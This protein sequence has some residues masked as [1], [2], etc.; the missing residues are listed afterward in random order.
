MPDSA[1]RHPQAGPLRAAIVY[2]F[3]GTLARGNLQERSFIPE[4][5]GVSHDEFWLD[6]KKTARAADADEILVYM[7]KMV[8]AARA[9]GKPFTRADLMKHGRDPDL[10]DGLDHWFDRMDA[11]A[12][13]LGVELEHYVISSC[14]HEMIE[15]TPIYRRFHRVFASKFLYDTKGEALWPALAI[16]Y[17][18]KTQFLYCINKG[19]EHIWDSEAINRWAP[20]PRR[21]IPFERMIFIGDGDTDIPSMKTV[22]KEGGCSI[23]VLDP[24]RWSDE[25]SVAKLHK[26]IAEDR[27]RFVAPAA[28]QPGEQLDVIVKGALERIALRAGLRAAETPV[29]R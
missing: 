13:D 7:Q 9:R 23:A 8:E 18:S 29:L 26:L 20:E 14:I 24:Y 10:F 12:A 28:Y 25:R 4:I 5:A 6:V 3:D 1:S 11:F 2:D 16:N 22:M 19:V 17:T 15:G 21:P 27:V